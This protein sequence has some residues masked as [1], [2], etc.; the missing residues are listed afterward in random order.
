MFWPAAFLI[1]GIC[2]S[3]IW[4]SIICYE[5]MNFIAAAVTPGA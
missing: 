5:L 3:A 1:L 2:L 4:V